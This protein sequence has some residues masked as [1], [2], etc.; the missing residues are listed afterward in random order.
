MKK[1]V[2]IISLIIS[3]LIQVNLNASNILNTLSECDHLYQTRE[4]SG[5]LEN[6]IQMALSHLETVE[7]DNDKMNCIRK[8]GLHCGLNLIL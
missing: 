7:T 8:Y 4:Q 6:S 3:G 5:H 2:V 1:C